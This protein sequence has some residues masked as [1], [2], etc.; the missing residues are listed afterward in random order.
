MARNARA[1]SKKDQKIVKES[2][3]TTAIIPE[4]S[5]APKVYT[6][7]D[8]AAATK[9]QKEKIAKKPMRRAVMEDTTSS[10]ESDENSEKRKKS[11]KKGEA[12]PRRWPSTLTP[13][14]FEI[15]STATEAAEEGRPEL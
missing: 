8:V 4:T 2:A 7:R 11:K 9:E 10:S 13:P 15:S 12:T 3:H 6:K 1:Y 14:I 5:N